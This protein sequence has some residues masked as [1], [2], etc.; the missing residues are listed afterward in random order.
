MKVKYKYVCVSPSELSLNERD[1]TE[2][3]STFELEQFLEFEEKLENII[4]VSNE[5]DAVYA[6]PLCCKFGVKLQI[7]CISR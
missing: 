3:I 2:H 4:V 7:N 1:L 6:A 5:E